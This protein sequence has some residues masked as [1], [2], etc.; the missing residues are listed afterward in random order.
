MLDRASIGV[1]ATGLAL[2]GVARYRRDLRRDHERLAKF[3]P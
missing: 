2:F 1:A 3:E